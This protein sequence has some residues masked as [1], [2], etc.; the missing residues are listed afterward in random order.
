MQIRDAEPSSAGVIR[1]ATAEMLF[2]VRNIAYMGLY[3]ENICLAADL[4]AQK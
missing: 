2:S 4:Q 1:S 3:E